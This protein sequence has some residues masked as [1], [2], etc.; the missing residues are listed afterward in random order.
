MITGREPI[1][2]DTDA[3]VGRA[4]TN[5]SAGRSPGAT[6]W[7]TG[8]SGAGKSTI[9]NLLAERLRETG[10]E[11]EVLDGDALRTTLCKDLGFSR[12]DREENIR[13]IGFLCELLTRHGVTV[14]VAAI[15]PYRNARDEVRTKLAN[16]VEVYVTCPL[17]VLTERDPKGLYRRALAGEIAHFTGIS[18]PYEPPEHADLTID[19]SAETPQESVQRLLEKMGEMGLGIKEVGSTFPSF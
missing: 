14:I 4:N 1:I 17:D 9:A 10:A 3:S 16:F 2:A 8:L 11:V 6:I 5:A 13:R 7:L 15:S 18:D 19:S 12:D